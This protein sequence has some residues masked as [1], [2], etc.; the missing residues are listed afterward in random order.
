MYSS[1]GR[2]GRVAERLKAPVLKTGENFLAWVRIPPLPF[3]L[4][5]NIKQ[6]LKMNTNK[7]VNLAKNFFSKE[8]QIQFFKK[9]KTS[10]K[11]KIASKLSIQSRAFFSFCQKKFYVNRFKNFCNLSSKPRGLSRS[12]KISSY[13]LKEKARKLQLLGVSRASW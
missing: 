11:P 7:Q 2:G 6:F 1:V 5:L 12:M 9:I 3:L 10:S 13:S 8:L 4:S